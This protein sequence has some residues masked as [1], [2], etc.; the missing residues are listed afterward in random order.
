MRGGRGVAAGGDSELGRGLRTEGCAR[1]LCQG[2]E[3]C[4]SRHPCR[5]PITPDMIGVMGGMHGWR[6]V[7]RK[8]VNK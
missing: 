8:F 2:E 5:P 7:P 6:E 1:G 3:F 4:K